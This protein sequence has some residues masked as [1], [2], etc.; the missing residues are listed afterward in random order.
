MATVQ[1]RH[2]G[3][4]LFSEFQESLRDQ[5]G[6]D[7]EKNCEY[8]YTQEHVNGYIPALSVFLHAFK[9]VEE[10]GRNAYLKLFLSRPFAYKTLDELTEDYLYLKRRG[11][12]AALP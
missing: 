3:D 5:Y 2:R 12:L 7:V 9:Y 6:I 1:I 10:S 4:S 8:G 11:L